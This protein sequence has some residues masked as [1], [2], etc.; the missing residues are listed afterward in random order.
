MIRRNRFALAGN[1]I[2]GILAN[3]KN[4]GNK[5]H[6]YQCQM[7]IIVGIYLRKLQIHIVIDLFSIPNILVI[8]HKNLDQ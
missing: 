7:R 5:R 8:I 1:F 2:C 3:T 4:F 6:A